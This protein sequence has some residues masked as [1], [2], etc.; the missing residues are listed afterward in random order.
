MVFY[1]KAIA[2]IIDAATFTISTLTLVFTSMSYSFFLN[3]EL[4]TL[5]EL[6]IYSIG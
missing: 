1:F 5:I 2:N 4:V 6:I 3:D